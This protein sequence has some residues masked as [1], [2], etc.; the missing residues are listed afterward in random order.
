MA[1]RLDETMGLRH[2]PKARAVSRIVKKSS[3][4][5]SKIVFIQGKKYFE[6]SN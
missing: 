2:E 1:A 4:K 3:F 5:F 6:Y